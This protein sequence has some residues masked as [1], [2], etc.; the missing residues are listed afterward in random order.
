[1]LYLNLYPEALL[2]LSIWSSSL[3][4]TNICC[5]TYLCDSSSGLQSKWLLCV[6]VHYGAGCENVQ[7]C[8]L[9]KTSIKVCC[10][11]I[12]VT[13][14][15]LWRLE[16]FFLC[17][18]F[19]NSLKKTRSGRHSSHF[20]WA[21]LSRWQWLPHAMSTSVEFWTKHIDQTEAWH[22]FSSGFVH[23]IMCNMG[24]QLYKSIYVTSEHN[25]SII[26]LL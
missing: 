26:W 23:L 12:T 10:W 5:I 15:V 20:I 22:T 6:P 8:E 21:Q 4:S 17:L 24:I 9:I 25:K 7:C 13:I 19:I 3:K 14:V 11:P 1:M 18:W 16:A 2:I